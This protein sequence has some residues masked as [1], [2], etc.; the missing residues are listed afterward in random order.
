VVIDGK[1]SES[2]Q[3]FRGV[4]QGSVLSPVL[5]SMVVDK[6]IRKVRST[7]GWI[8]KNYDKCM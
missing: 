7:R 2:S 4:R 6:I 1:K 3:T 8:T 5:F